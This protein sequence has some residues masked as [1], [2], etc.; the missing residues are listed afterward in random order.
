MPAGPSTELVVVRFSPWGIE[1]MTKSMRLQALGDRGKS[2]P[3]RHG[4]SAFATALAPGESIDDAI[5]RL[6]EAITPA[7]TNG[8]RISVVTSSD[9]RRLGYHVHIDEPPEHHCLIGGADLSNPPDLE[10]LVTLFRDRR[11]NPAWKGDST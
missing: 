6:C 1:S 9:L 5:V 10:H 2:R 11:P 3:E 7:F 4:V 8:D